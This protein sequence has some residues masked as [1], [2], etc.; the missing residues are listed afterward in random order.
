LQLTAVII[1]KEIKTEKI[2]TLAFIFFI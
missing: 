2:R 1:R